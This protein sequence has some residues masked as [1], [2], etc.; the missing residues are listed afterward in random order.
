VAIPSKTN[1]IKVCLVSISLG[2][3]GAE[4][5]CAMLSQILTDEGFDVHIAF[6]N[7]GELFE[8]SGKLLNLGKGKPV[9]STFFQRFNRIKKLKRYLKSEQ[10]D[11][12]IDHR[13]KNQYLREQFYTNYVYNKVNTIYVIHSYRLETYFGK[14]PEKFKKLYSQNF[15]NVAV[16]RKI[17][18]HVELK[19]NLS[20]LTTIYNAYDPDWVLKSKETIDIPAKKYIL[21]YGRIDDDV[22][23]FSFLIKAFDESNLW[24]KNIKLVIMGDGKDVQKLKKLAEKLQIR[25][26]VIFL[27]FTTNPFP[28]ITNAHFVTLTS[29]WE[30]FPMIL[31]ESLTVGTPVVSLDITSGPS[32]IIQHKKNGLLISKREVPL[33]AKAMRDF[34][35]NEDLYKK[36]K[37]FTFPSIE[38]FTKQNIGKQWKRLLEDE[39]Q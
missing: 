29:R 16:S 22:K 11:F 38:K 21:S 33:F 34:F 1:K 9:K 10:I 4:R 28:Y 26:E 35:S 20:N 32:E 27:P 31:L 36:C 7:D 2:N 30:G 6:L 8:Y 37:D 19:L 13:P 3:G 17:K 18:E 39:K 15:K 23:D 12:V 14:H 25:D 24:K 5:S